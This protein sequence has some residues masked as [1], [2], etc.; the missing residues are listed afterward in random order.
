[1]KFL[2]LL[3]A[4]VLVPCARA[5]TEQRIYTVPDPAATGGI[6]GTVNVTVTHA[7]AVD[8]ERVHV[9]RA[10]MSNGGKTFVFPHLPV[11]KYDLVL[12]TNDAKVYEG[13][14]LG[15][16]KKDL[17]AGS[18]ENLQKCVAAQ[19][20]FFNRSKIH[21]IG[22]DGDNAFVFVERIRDKP[23]LKQ[24]GETLKATLR[25]LEIIEIAQAADN[26]QVTINRHIYREEQP[27]NGV[28][29][30]RH[31]YVPEMGG[32]RVIDRVKDLG[33]ILLSPL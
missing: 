8:H 30:L 33:S 18:M 23:I 21:R 1:M 26:W 6:R 12:V 7:L 29:D 5:D 17:P 27:L 4:L 20:A 13:L 2:P 19:D 25:R 22:F 15:D 3:A 9:Y 10:D 24:S 31:L 28:N 16:E 11:G 14:T 32:L